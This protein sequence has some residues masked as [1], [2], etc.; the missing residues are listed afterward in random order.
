MS[1]PSHPRALTIAGSDSGG[2]AGIQAD[3]KTFMALGV[4]GSSVITALT[5]QNSVGVSSVHIPPPEFI[6]DQ[7]RAV[8]TDI[9]PEAAKIGM[10]GSADAARAVVEGLRRWPI[11]DLVL[12]PV[13]IST[14]GAILLERAAVETL[15]GDLLPLARVITPNI[16]E[17]LALLDEPLPGRAI[18]TEAEMLDLAETLMTLGPRAVLLKGGHMAA[19]E[20]P[21]LLL[22]DK[23][24]HWFRAPRI[25]SPHTHGSGCTLSAAIAAGLAKG[26]ELPDAI[27]AAKNYVTGAI[28]AAYTVGSGPGPLNHGWN[29]RFDS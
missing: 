7:M 23:G 1:S 11:P 12:D 6:L 21:D 16:P 20:S 22:S 13:M 17:A 24:A 19:D 4:Y 3:L 26:Y 8:M 27:A 14:T 28:Q 25:H 18:R 10:L 5:A 15:R 29:L 9:K 2:G